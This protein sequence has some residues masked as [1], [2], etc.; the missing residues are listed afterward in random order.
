MGV[1][2]LTAPSVA[3]GGVNGLWWIDLKDYGITAEVGSA[4]D[5]HNILNIVPGVGAQASRYFESDGTDV[6]DPASAP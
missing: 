3:A 6:I 2:E 4:N 1:A 5:P